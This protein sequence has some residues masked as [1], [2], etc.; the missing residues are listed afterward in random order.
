MN[1]LITGSAGFIG[2]NLV[3]EL[4][5]D[6]NI[7][8]FD[9]R[10]HKPS[11]IYNLVDFSKIDFVYHLG[12]VSSTLEKNLD[13]LYEHNVSFS[14]GLFN[15][16][17]KHRIPTVYTSS[18]SVFGNTMKDCQYIYNP[19]NYYATT[20]M[21]TE[22]WLKE[23]QNQ[24]DFLSVPRLF[25]VYGAD[26]QKSDMS[27]SPVCKFKQQA[28][29]KGVITV[30][31]GSEHMIRDF[32]C[33]DDV[34]RCFKTLLNRTQSGFFDV[35]TSNPISF[36]EVAEISSKKYNVPIEFVDMPDFMKD[37]YQFYTRARPE[38]GIVYTSV[39]QWLETH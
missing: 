20:K 19:L 1:I 3:N 6:H 12:A 23:R 37:G 17:I 26:E 9:T 32:V 4:Q 5:T 31:N 8:T 13:V 16:A 34:I 29:E 30:F 18:A 36:Q 27:T 24:F 39:N 7:V 25:N 14:I 22:M 15:T 11:D 33:I 2:R 28:L 35:G 10:Y 21:L 38:F